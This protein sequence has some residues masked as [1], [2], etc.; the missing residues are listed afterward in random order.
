MKYYLEGVLIAVGVVDVLPESLS[1]VYFFYDPRYRK[2]SLG[3]Y[4]A[5]R[6]I[7]FVKQKLVQGMRYYY[8]GF[9]IQDSQKMV[10][11]GE[12]MTSE[13]LCPI[14][15]LWVELDDEVKKH[16]HEVNERMSGGDLAY[17]K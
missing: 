17:Y 12:Y 1:S 13:I 11:K 3:V 16:I 6:E 7:E 14:T 15:R 4:G 5:L 8:L 9:Y 2:Y 10:Y